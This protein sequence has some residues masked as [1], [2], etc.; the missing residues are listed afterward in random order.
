MVENCK[1]SNKLWY[2]KPADSWEKA[3]PLGNGRL[4]AMMFGGVEKEKIQLNE[5]TLWSGYPMDFYNY[6]ASGALKTVREKLFDRKFREAQYLLEKNMLGAFNQS[7]L[8]MADIEIE[9]DNPEETGNSECISNYRRELELDR[10]VNTVQYDLGTVNFRRQAFISAVE[11]AFVYKV[12][13]NE[14]G[15][16]N[17][18]IKLSSQLRSTTQVIGQN[19]LMLEGECPSNVTP[20]YIK[21]ENPVVYA[22][23]STG[24]GMKFGVLLRVRN[25]G[26]SIQACG[27]YLKVTEVDSLTVFVTAATSYNGFDRNPATDGK[28]YKREFTEQMKAAASKS[29]EQLLKDHVEDYS[30]LFGRMEISLGDRDRSSIPTDMRLE[31]VKGGEQDPQLAALFLQYGRYLLISSSRRGTQ[32]ANLQGIWSKELRSYWSCNWTTNINAQMNYWLAEVCNL[33]ECHEPLF[34]LIDGLRAKGSKVAEIHYK[35]RGWVTHHN[36]DIWRS[37]IPAGGW[38]NFFWAGC[39]FWPMGG[40][41][42]CRHLWEHYLYNGDVK[43]LAER[44]YPVMKDAALFCLDWMVEDGK[45]NLVTNPST[46]PENAYLNEAGEKCNVSISTTMDMS[47]IK[48]L[49]T[50]CIAASVILD[51][52]RDFSLQLQ[53][54]VK[55]L[56]PYKVGKYGQLQ[57]WSED[58]EDFEPGHRHVSHLYGLYPG[59]AITPE[60]NPEL[61]K[62]CRVSIGRRLSS[63]GGGTGWSLAWLLNLY[64]RLHDAEGAKKLVDEMLANSVYPNL[65]DLHPPLGPEEQVVFQIDGNFG[66]AAGI[67]E[68]LLQSHNGIVHLLPA[69]P[70]EWD[71]GYVKGLKARGGFEI[72]MEWSAGELVQAVIKAGQTSRCKIKYGG[73]VTEVAIEKGERYTLSE[74]W[75]KK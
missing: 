44:A 5:D 65:F 31:A 12:H 25:V 64:S 50:S 26:G 69:L 4:G 24:K 47:I 59:A 9:F 54:A 67:A 70:D 73:T 66:A 35:C 22:G 42:L 61:A 72:D 32:P 28:D 29:F 71:S 60:E 13:S 30:N 46:S 56:L 1:I 43:F 23:D 16:I 14:S 3:L 51:I 68:M 63:G 20:H 8:P 52:D 49:F 17:M 7:Y 6:N 21:D 55:R 33:A 41:W 45:G 36:V 15:K 57:E 53:E 48:E 19:D 18:R 38:P 39:S 37:T 62:A 75:L 2:T 34:D 74:S 58:F 10:A 27:E 11:Q 40:A